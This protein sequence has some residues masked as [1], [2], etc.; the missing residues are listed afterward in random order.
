MLA[1]TRCNSVM[2]SNRIVSS[3]LVCPLSELSAQRVVRIRG[4]R[5]GDCLY[6]S[7]VDG[8]EGLFSASQRKSTGSALIAIEGKLL[9]GGNLK[10]SNDHG[11][12]D[13]GF[14]AILGPVWRTHSTSSS[15]DQVVSPMRC[16]C[17]HSVVPSLVSPAAPYLCQF[18]S[19]PQFNSARSV[20]KILKIRITSRLYDQHRQHRRPPHTLGLP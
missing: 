4:G 16:G 17:H 20:L 14:T 6:W 1:T 19:R 7:R 18:L 9:V 5:D 8:N 10:L 13:R 2:T 15:I 3:H 11:R 12:T